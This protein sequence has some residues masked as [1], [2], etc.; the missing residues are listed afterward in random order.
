MKILIF[1]DFEINFNNFDTKNILDEDTFYEEIINK[2][3][4]VLIISF[5]FFKEFL[6]I[7]DYFKGYTIFL[8]NYCDT[9]IY[10]KILEVA[11]FCYEIYDY[12]KLLLRLVYLRKKILNINSFVFKYNN[13]LYNFNSNQCYINSN[14]VK[15]SNAENELLKILIKNQNRFISKEEIINNSEYIDSFES[16]K[17]IISRLRKFG[18]E[19]ENKKNLGYKLKKGVI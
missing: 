3:Y 8:T 11:D 1:T 14:L 2:K 6:E 13:L 18:I 4:D 19:I 10:K 9:F 15:L 16:I 7:K 12:D 17:V 5:S